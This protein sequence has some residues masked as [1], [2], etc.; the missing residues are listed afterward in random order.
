MIYLREDIR[1]SYCK[2]GMFELDWIT[3]EAKQGKTWYGRDKWFFISSEYVNKL[4]NKTPLQVYKYLRKS[5]NK[6]LKAKE[7]AQVK[8]DEYLNF[9]K[10]YR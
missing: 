2:G 5:F 9:I 10:P 3:L 7:A 8:K 4:N 1:L 6:E